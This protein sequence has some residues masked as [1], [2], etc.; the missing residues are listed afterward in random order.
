[1]EYHAS[2]WV[3]E[4]GDNASSEDESRVVG[5]DVGCTLYVDTFFP[6]GDVAFH[7][8][9]VFLLENKPHESPE[10]RGDLS[11]VRLCSRPPKFDGWVEKLYK[12][13]D[14][15]PGNSSACQ[16]SPIHME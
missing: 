12:V 2:F 6:D 13:I 8:C 15:P 5:F 7:R 9:I 1:M 4:E 11:G 10:E 14:S 16:G 3:Q